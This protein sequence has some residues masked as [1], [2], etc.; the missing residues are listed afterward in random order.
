MIDR[1]RH[2]MLT[3]RSKVNSLRAREA[4]ERI[5]DVDAMAVDAD[6][7]PSYVESTARPHDREF[8]N[9]G[10]PSAAGRRRKL[11]TGVSS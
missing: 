7:L 1:T 9:R 2:S 4:S 3:L 10:E 5:V 8:F 6:D 11:S